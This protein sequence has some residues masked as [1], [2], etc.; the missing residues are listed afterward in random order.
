MAF[1]VKANPTP[2][3][4]EAERARVHMLAEKEAREGRSSSPFA[5]IGWKDVE[6]DI[7]NEP[8][9]EKIREIDEKKS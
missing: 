7:E 6:D 5:S 3:E 9:R 1:E 2:E 8:A 4:F